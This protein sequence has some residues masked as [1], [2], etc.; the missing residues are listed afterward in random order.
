MSHRILFGEAECHF[1]SLIKHT[2][3][4]IF[5]CSPSSPEGSRKLRFPDFMTKAQDGGKIVSLKHRPPLPPWNPP[6]T[7]FC[8]R[9]SRLQCHSAIGRI[10]CQWKI[11]MTPAGIELATFR[12]TAQH[13]NHCATAVP[14][15]DNNMRWNLT[16]YGVRVWAGFTRPN[17]EAKGRVFGRS[18]ENLTSP[19]PKKSMEC[20]DHMKYHQ[21]LNFHP[22][23]R[24]SNVI[25]WPKNQAPFF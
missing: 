21:L 18:N 19:P 5:F 20:F 12:F 1:G 7:H 4:L 13:L 6:G 10:L 17:T 25:A 22:H 8:L 15:E 9:V 3:K 16:K 24:A 14:F 11:P 23:G 2:R